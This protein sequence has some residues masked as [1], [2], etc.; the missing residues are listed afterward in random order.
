MVS[1]DPAMI[2]AGRSGA[3]CAT[4]P[5]CNADTILLSMTVT[6][7]PGRSACREVLV[8]PLQDAPPGV[9]SRRFVE[10]RPGAAEE[11]VISV[12]IPHDRRVHR[13]VRHRAAKALDVL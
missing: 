10:A 6:P 5:M 2:T 3:R 4:A 11:A 8:E 9:I 13:R 1:P 7:A 12:G